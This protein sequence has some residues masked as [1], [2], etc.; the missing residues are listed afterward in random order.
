MCISFMRSYVVK[1]L[2]SLTTWVTP[3]VLN[4]ASGFLKCE[5]SVCLE[6]TSI[7]AGLFSPDTYLELAG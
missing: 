5:A 3:S 1:L 4:R 2:F 7:R 6:R